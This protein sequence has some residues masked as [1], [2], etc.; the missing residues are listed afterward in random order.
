MP[1]FFSYTLSE[2]AYLLMGLN[3]QEYLRFSRLRGVLPWVV[4]LWSTVLLYRAIISAAGWPAFARVV[5]Y[6]VATLLF[7]CLFW[8][9]AT[10]FGLGQEQVDGRQIRS[11]VASADPQNEIQTAAEVPVVPEAMRG[12][13]YWSPGFRLLLP[14]LLQWPLTFAQYINSRVDR[15]FASTLPLQWLLGTELTGDATSALNDWTKGCYL[16]AL[17]QAQQAAS[18]R[19]EGD[20]LPWGDGAVAQ[21]LAQR[22]ILPG[23]TTALA[24]RWLFA[25]VSPET[26]MTCADYLNRVLEETERWLLEVRSPAGRPLLE[27]FRDEL[28]MEPLAQAQFLVRREIQKQAEQ[29]VA[30]PSVDGAYA[31]LRA[32]SLAS[33]LGSALVGGGLS[34]GTVTGALTNE[35]SRTLDQL[36]IIVR[37][38]LALTWWLPDF[39]GITQLVLLAFFPVYYVFYVLTP[40]HQFRGMVGYFGYLAYA[41]SLPLW[42]AIID[43]VSQL[44]VLGASQ[45]VPGAGLIRSYVIIIIGLLTVQGIFAWMLWRSASNVYNA[46]RGG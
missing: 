37:I 22:Q 1:E 5:G 11:F 13:V 26:E 34:F 29:V 43:N 44:S 17:A 36:T 35:F 27:V 19:T 39:M 18:L 7:T 31:G 4:A 32:L 24:P 9:E 23:A 40:G 21:A 42:W 30:A 28:G 6:W 12:P 15:P 41:C 25:F 45:G 2:A 16:P 20:A 8:P 10:R 46:L 14:A 3:I 33:R 38:A